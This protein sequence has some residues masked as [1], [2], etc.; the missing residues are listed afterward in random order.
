MLAYE[1]T[2][3]LQERGARVA[4]IVMLDAPDSTHLDVFQF[5]RR[6]ATFQAVNT[7]LFASIAHHPER[8]EQTLIHRDEVDAALDDAALLHQLM[9]LAQSR[10]L[11]KDE[12]QVRFMVE[13]NARVHAA[14]DVGRFRLKPLLRPEEVAVFYLRNGSC[15][16]FGNLE[17]YLT[18]MPGELTFDGTNYWAEWER[19]LPR[20]QILE[21][22][23]SN[24]LMLLAEPAVQR[25]IA[26][27]C[28]R[29]YG[30]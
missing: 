30:K 11:S 25:V 10:G 1:V 16:F 27:F 12:N 24:H 3:Q 13:Q 5:S 19:F 7:A 20:M 18:L 23:S 21:V 28:A 14:Y 29:F 17:P 2:R 6:T 22:A 26:G 9:G 4:S 15:S 8:L